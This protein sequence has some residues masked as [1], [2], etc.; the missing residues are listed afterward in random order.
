MYR[1][2]IVEDDEIIA[3]SLKKHLESWDYDVVCVEDFSDV[4]KEFAG[5]APQ[6]VLMDIK[7]PFYNGYHWCSRIRE[8]SKVP[9]I[10]VSSASDNMN[11]VMAVNMGGDDFIAKPFDLDVL[12]AKIQALLR[13]TYDFAGQ[14]TVLEHRGALL[15]L[16]DATLTCGETRVEPARRYSNPEDHRAAG[17]CRPQNCRI[18]Q[19]NPGGCRGSFAL[20]CICWQRH[21]ATPRIFSTLFRTSA[22]SRPEPFTLPAISCASTSAGSGSAGFAATP[23]MVQ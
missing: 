6:L 21:H 18:K 2:L 4:M 1:I 5:A 12:T 9:V 10:F 16:G 22:G 8:V 11:I 17:L 14:N 23:W 19:K 13:R 15:N 3:R 20:S 7:L